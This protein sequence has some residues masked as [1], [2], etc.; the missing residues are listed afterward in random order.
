MASGTPSSGL[1][2][3]ARMASC[4]YQEVEK[5]QIRRITK[6]TI[7]DYKRARSILDPLCPAQV[8]IGNLLGNGWMI[9]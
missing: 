2:V 5:E 3:L 1:R 7:S 8:L 9:N 6:L 4:G